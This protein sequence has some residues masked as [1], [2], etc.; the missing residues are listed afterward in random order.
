[1]GGAALQL[2]L[3]QQLYPVMNGYR[4]RVLMAKQHVFGPVISLD[5]AY[6]AFAAV[7]PVA[8]RQAEIL[9]V[10]VKAG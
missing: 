2:G 7:L 3:L 9:I 6:E 10:A 5:M 4:Q 1:M 8:A